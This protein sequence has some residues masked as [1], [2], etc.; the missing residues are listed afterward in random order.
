[1]TLW[2][3]SAKQAPVTRPTYPEPII[4]ISIV[5]L[6]EKEPFTYPASAFC[7][8]ER[9]SFAAL[10]SR[11]CPQNPGTQILSQSPMALPTFI[12]IGNPNRGRSFRVK[13]T[14]S[15]ICRLLEP[16]LTTFKAMA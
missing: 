1:M 14:T 15:S 3:T 2:P 13:V 9:Y 4:A 8:E 16:L 12:L 5:L 7:P 11:G 10:S 6:Q